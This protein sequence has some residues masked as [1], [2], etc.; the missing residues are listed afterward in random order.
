MNSSWGKWTG[1]TIYKKVAL[2]CAFQF[3]KDDRSNPLR[4]NFPHHYFSPDVIAIE[5]KKSLNM[6]SANDRED[7]PVFKGPGLYNIINS[8]AGT[9]LDLAESDPAPG[10]KIVG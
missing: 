2:S 10:A 4:S 5:H 1:L 7:Y 9:Y 3:F 8:G 6:S